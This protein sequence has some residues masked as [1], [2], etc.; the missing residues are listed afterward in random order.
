VPGGPAV[1]DASDRAAERQAAAELEAWRERAV[2]DPAAPLEAEDVA[3]LVVDCFAALGVDTNVGA[4]FSVNTVHYYRRKDVMDAPEGKTSAARYGLR[5]VWQAAGARLAGHLGLVT[6]AEARDVMREASEPTLL[7]FVA[8]RVA[9]AR[10]RQA[11]RESAEADGARPLPGDADGTE[12]PPAPAARAPS[13]NAAA[14]AAE[15]ALPAAGD[16]PLPATVFALPGGA[17]CV[18]PS[19]HAALRSPHDARAL[20]RALA[21]ALRVS[22]ADEPN[23]GRG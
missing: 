13:R 20:V 7:A 19:A 11:L 2:P 21:T 16:P 9:D 23:D 18:V 6:L 10:A 22:A 14:P 15:A 1:A 3:R 4:G 17:W 8:A 5:H 12:P